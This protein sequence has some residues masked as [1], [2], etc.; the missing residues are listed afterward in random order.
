MYGSCLLY[1]SDHK[2]IISALC[3]GGDRCWCPRWFL[4]QA[5]D[6]IYVIAL[7]RFGQSRPIYHQPETS[8]R[9]ATTNHSCRTLASSTAQL[10][11]DSAFVARLVLR[12]DN[13]STSRESIRGV[14]SGV[15]PPKRLKAMARICVFIIMW[16]RCGCGRADNLIHSS[17]AL[18]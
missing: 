13:A 1:M 11:F 18:I 10:P 9:G 8:V 5:K 2:V 16:V 12:L 14:G 3:S 7:L 6:S 17:V 4:P 15:H